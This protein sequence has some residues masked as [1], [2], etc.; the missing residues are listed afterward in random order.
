MADSDLFPSPQECCQ[1]VLSDILKELSVRN[2]LDLQQLNECCLHD[3]KYASSSEVILNII[4]MCQF[5]QQNNIIKYAAIE[6]FDRVL[7]RLVCETKRKFL[8]STPGSYEWSQIELKMCQQMHLRAATCVVMASKMH[9]VLKPI[10]MKEM[11][12]FLQSSGSTNYSLKVL[13]KS[14]QRVIKLMAFQLSFT[15]IHTY[16]ETLL[17][18]LNYNN[19]NITWNT[20]FPVAEDI[21]EV[22]YL[23]RCQ[24]IQLFWKIKSKRDQT[25]D[26]HVDQQVA[27]QKIAADKMLISCAIIASVPA[28]IN[29]S[30]T[31][32]VLIELEDVTLI[33]RDDIIDLSLIILKFVC[34]L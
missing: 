24:I 22:Y 3:E 31:D 29:I 33:K 14:E 32:M 15:S 6:L 27:K 12:A 26:Q 11:L 20:F 1:H 28:F 16:V 23:S 7:M 9:S 5:L 10:S 17:S 25:E 18:I 19:Q 34:H 13:N 4:N 30:L 8:E 2:A 21:I